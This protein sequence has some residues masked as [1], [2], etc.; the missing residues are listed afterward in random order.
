MHFLWVHNDV[1]LKAALM[2]HTDAA[3]LSGFLGR[4]RPVEKLKFL[5]KIIYACIHTHTH[6]HIHAHF[7]LK[8]FYPHPTLHI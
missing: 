7:I 4:I 2:R 6:A 5:K 3:V 1:T 8:A